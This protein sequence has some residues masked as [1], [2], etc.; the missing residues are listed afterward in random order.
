VSDPDDDDRGPA[1]PRTWTPRPERAPTASGASGAADSLELAAAVL[2]VG[3]ST[4]SAIFIDPGEPIDPVAGI[5]EK[6]GLRYEGDDLGEMRAACAKVARRLIKIGTLTAARV[7]GFVPAGDDVAVPPVMIQLALSLSN[8]TGSPTAVVDAN[9]RY[10]GL[11]A[12]A[13]ERQLGDTVYSTR[14]VSQSVALLS[15]RGLERAGEV[16]PQL[17]R[18]VADGADLFGHMLVDLTGFELIGEHASAAAGMDLVVV[19]GRTHRTREPAL[20]ALAQ[21]LPPD[22]FLGVLLV[23]S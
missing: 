20:L 16:V 8:Q 4:A 14:W 9:V 17:A 3:D 23:G 22:K 5:L 10:P 19:V 18:V 1:P 2:S 6:I 12:L 15:P 13:S 21:V 7:I 11:S